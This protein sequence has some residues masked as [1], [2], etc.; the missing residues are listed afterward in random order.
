VVRSVCGVMTGTIL[1]REGL[2]V[3]GDGFREER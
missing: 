2:E 3:A 1:R